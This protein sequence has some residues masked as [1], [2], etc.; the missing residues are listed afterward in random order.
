MRPKDLIT[1]VQRIADTSPRHS[2]ITASDV[3]RVISETFK[4]LSKLSA[5]EYAATTAS[6]AKLGAKNLAKDKAKKKARKKR[7]DNA[8]TA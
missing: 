2:H 6:L 7:K 5:E 8:R 3:S 1:T 4:E